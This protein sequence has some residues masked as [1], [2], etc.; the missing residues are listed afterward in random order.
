MFYSYDEC[1]FGHLVLLDSVARGPWSFARASTIDVR[2]SDA[3]KSLITSA[4]LFLRL[5][6]PE[7]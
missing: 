1:E 6:R 3:A 5:S 7:K 2:A 4:W